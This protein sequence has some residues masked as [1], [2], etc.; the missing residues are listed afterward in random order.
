MMARLALRLL[1]GLDT[2]VGGGLLALAWYCFHSRLHG[3]F[4]WT[5]LN[6]AASVFLGGQVFYS[7]LGKATVIGS[8]VLIVLYGVAGALAGSV[9]PVRGGFIV[10]LAS[11]LAAAY[12]FHLLMEHYGWR[13][14]GPAASRYFPRGATVPAHCLFAL[15]LMRFGRRWRVLNESDISPDLPPESP[16]NLEADSGL[17]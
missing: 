9:L 15:S 14:L 8:A 11:A 17:P 12:V 2:G 4:W 7:G 10:R 5:K 16:A 6:V 3:E 1:A 13:M